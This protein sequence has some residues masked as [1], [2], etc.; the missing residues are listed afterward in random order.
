MSNRKGIEAFVYVVAAILCVIRI[1][2]W[3]WGTKIYP[4]YAGWITVP[5]IYQFF[6]WLAGTA[7]VYIICFTVWPEDEA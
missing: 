5:M 3:W 4:I 2:F 6:I 7:L 1:D